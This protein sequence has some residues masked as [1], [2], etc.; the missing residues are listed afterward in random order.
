MDDDWCGSYRLDV[1]TAPAHLGSD[2]A[3]AAGADLH[4]LMDRVAQ[5][6]T[7][8]DEAAMALAVDEVHAVRTARRPAATS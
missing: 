8:D 2:D 4:A 3:R 5:R 6:S 1:M 7:L